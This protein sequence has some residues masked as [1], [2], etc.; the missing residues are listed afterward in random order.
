MAPLPD[1]SVL[2]YGL[3]ALFD[4]KA[5]LYVPLNVEPG[6]WWFLARFASHCTWSRWRRGMKSYVSLNRGKFFAAYDELE[7]GGVS[8]PTLR[9]SILAGFEH[10]DHGDWAPRGSCRCTR[11]AGQE[12]QVPITDWSPNW[13]PCPIAASRPGPY[14][15]RRGVCKLPAVEHHAIARSSS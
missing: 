6:L 14:T 8:S 15:L 1:P 3:R 9:S 12:V 10:R 7:A 13:S 5:A 2:R 11:E 4:P